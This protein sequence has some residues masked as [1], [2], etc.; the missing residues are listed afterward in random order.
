[1]GT[2]AIIFTIL[3]LMCAN[4][5]QHNPDQFLGFM[6]TSLTTKTTDQGDFEGFD[7]QTSQI[8]ASAALEENEEE[9]T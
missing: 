9:E 4:A 7:N 8:V 1:M 5:T 3:L 6:E 2:Q